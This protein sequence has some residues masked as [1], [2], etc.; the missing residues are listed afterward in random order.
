MVQKTKS[1]N[2]RITPPKDLFAPVVDFDAIFVP[3]D[4]RAIGQI[5]PMLAYHDIWR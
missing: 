2:M 4:I 1:F 3:D 5:A